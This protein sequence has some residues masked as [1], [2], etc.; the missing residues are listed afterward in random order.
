[1]LFEQRL[2]VG[3][4]DGSI[5]VIFRRWKRPQV[6][7]GGHYRTGVDMIAVDTVD[8]VAPSAITLRDA[9]RAGYLS[10]EAVVRDLRGADDLP[11]YRIRLHRLDSPDPRDVL[12]AVAVLSAAEVAEIDKRLARLDAASSHGPWTSRALGMIAE[13]PDVRAPDLAASVGLE[14]AVFKL[15][16]R[17]L[18]ALGL[19]LSQPVGYRLS[20]RGR[21]Y[22]TAV[23]DRA[24][25]LE[26]MTS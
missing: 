10:V 26:T 20:R 5:T 4:H 23:A 12:A 1:V 17:K 2:K 13:Q 24:E 21:A 22:R 15:D 8:V 7:A 9:K 3:I 16:I 19:T 25:R 6:V 14:T 18:K 11:V